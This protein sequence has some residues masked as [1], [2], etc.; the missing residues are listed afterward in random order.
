[1]VATT[2][3]C[4]C[5]FDHLVDHAEEGA[6]IELRLRV[7]FRSGNAEA[8]LQVLFVADQHVDV[9]HDAVEHF[10]RAL[11]PPEMFQSFAR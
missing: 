5:F 3:T 11:S 8:L 10:D 7:H 1:M 4:G 6:G 2:L 9:L